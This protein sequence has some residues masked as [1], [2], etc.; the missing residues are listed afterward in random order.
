MTP[1]VSWNQIDRFKMINIDGK[2]IFI[3]Y[4]KIEI[5]GNSDVNNVDVDRIKSVLI[6]NKRKYGA[7]IV[8]DADDFQANDYVNFV[9]EFRTTYELNRS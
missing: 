6:D 9:E 8:I 2:S 7:E 4:L 1:L 3:I 5:L